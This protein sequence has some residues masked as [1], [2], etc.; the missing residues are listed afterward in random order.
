VIVHIIPAEKFVDRAIQLFEQAVPGKNTFYIFSQTEG[1]EDLKFVLTKESKSIIKVPFGTKWWKKKFI[2]FSHFSHLFLHNLYSPQNIHFANQS[3][4]G[5]VK[6]GIIWGYGYYGFKEFWPE[7]KYGALTTQFL[8]DS[9]AS[10]IDSQNK[11]LKKYQYLIKR[12][13]KLL[14]DKEYKVYN[15]TQKDRRSA[16]EASKYIHTH[17]KTDYQNIKKTFNKNFIWSN[18]SYYTAEDY[19]VDDSNLIPNKIL[20]GNSAT[21]S[22]NHLEAFDICYKLLQNSYFDII[23]PLNYGDIRYA[24]QIENRGNELFKKNF[25]AIE[26]FLPFEKYNEIQKSC[27]IVIMNHYRQQAAGNIIA[28]LLFGSKVFMNKR[29]P[30]YKHLKNLGLHIYDLESDFSQNNFSKTL[31][32]SDILKNREIIRDYYSRKTQVN[33]IRKSISS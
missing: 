19:K 13:W 1:G 6:H 28:S 25:L 22:N 10:K 7:P 31:D 26:Q 11:T 9:N 17:V 32:K 24:N 27:G 4:S 3:P 20:V 2:D 5:L 18:F 12:S 23:C 16:F 21:A 8:N 14:T 30:L 15:P 33:A 29:S